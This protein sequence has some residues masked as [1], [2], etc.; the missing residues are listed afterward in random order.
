MIVSTLYKMTKKNRLVSLLFFITFVKGLIFIF[1]IPPFQTPDEPN[2]Y[3]YA[4]YLSKINIFDYLGGKFSVREIEKE[5]IVTEE[6]KHL[7]SLT[8]FA[9]IPFHYD[10]KAKI[11][12]FDFVKDSRTYKSQDTPISLSKEREL[13]RAFNYPPLYYF[14]ESNV[15]RL[16]DVFN[17]NVAVK[18][19]FARFFSFLLFFAALFFAYKSLKIINFSTSTNIIILTLIALQPQLSM[20]SIS[21]Q[22]D[23]L[24]L[25]LITAGLYFALKFVNDFV[26]S[27]PFTR[28]CLS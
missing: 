6:V 23:I 9:A 18:F 10:E 16:A 25:L 11:G 20:L 26:F 27:S 1:L 14:Y 19:L 8:Q 24:A 3:D 4:V 22:P 12:L 2:H 7:L 28:C 17:V 15:L 5:K 21:V 13:G